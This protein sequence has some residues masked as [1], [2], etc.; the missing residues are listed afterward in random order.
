[1]VLREK[2]LPDRERADLA[3][4]LDGLLAG[5]WTARGKKKKKKQKKKK[6]KKKKKKQKVFFFFFF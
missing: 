6:K 5:D 1:M 2:D 4:R 3:A